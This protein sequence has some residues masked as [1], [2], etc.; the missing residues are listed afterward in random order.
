MVGPTTFRNFK[1]K[2]HG[3]TIIELTIVMALI[4]ILVGISF[5]F[6]PTALKK[7]R[8]SERA[9]DTKTLAR[10]F[11]Q[12]YKEQASVSYPSY[13]S[14]TTFP[15]EMNVLMNG[16]LKESAKAPGQTTNSVTS[17]VNNGDLTGVA[18]DQ[19]Y[20]YQPFSS[21]GALCTTSSSNSPCTRFKIWYKTEAT[22]PEV[23]VVESRYQ[24]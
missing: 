20:I 11:E 24:Q 22:P 1:V 16:G 6:I 14:T 2:S 15:S 19:G 9:S 5:A 8:N 18:T 7:A 3:F 12:R 17:A 23:R 4:G 10:F 21:N 13:P